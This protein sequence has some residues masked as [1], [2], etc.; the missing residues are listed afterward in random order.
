MNDK[1]IVGEG[2][3]NLKAEGC[4]FCIRIRPTR[5]LQKMLA[6]TAL[7]KPARSSAMAVASS[8]RL[9]ARR[10]MSA[11]LSG[12]KLPARREMSAVASAMPLD[13]NAAAAPALYTF[14]KRFSA[15]MEVVVSK[16]FPAGFGWQTASI[17][18]AQH[19]LEADSFNFALAT[20]A[21]DFAGV[22]VGHSLFALYKALS[23]KPGGLRSDLVTGLWLSSAAFCS[24]AAWQPVVNFLHDGAGA[25]F[26][27]TAVG[28]GAATG[29][30]FFVGLRLGRVVFEPLGLPK[31]DYANL[32]GDAML[33]ASIGAAT[34][35]FVATDISFA[36]NVLSPYL[37]I[38]DSMSDLQGCMRAGLST[39]AGFLCMQTLQN[40]A[41]PRHANWLDP[42]KL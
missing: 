18:G 34:G 2:A 6:P 15:T 22:L 39:S 40:L 12:S 29:A 7:R 26:V 30:C 42:V 41:L 25:N 4:N 9:L 33:S 11:V 16:I 5:F 35:T 28:C 3:K 8:R 37:G 1:N 23:A 21:G 32:C 31:A 20:G 10:G 24:G 14:T 13:D 38:T 17:I 27:S 36:D 19:G